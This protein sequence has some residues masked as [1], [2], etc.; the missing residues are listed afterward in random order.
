MRLVVHAGFHKTG[1][2]SVQAMLRKNAT[3]LS[4]HL[5][6]LLKADFDGLAEASRSFSL[7]PSEE[8][9]TTA[10]GRAARMLRRIDPADPRPV[11]ISSEDLSGTLPGRRGLEGYDAAPLLLAGLA[12]QARARFGDALDLTF[13]FSTREAGAWLRSTWWQ[14]LRS[15]RL[16]LSF[17]DYAAGL[18]TAADMA[19]VLEEVAAAVAPATVVSERLEISRDR[20]EGPL[21]PLLDL[22]ALPGEVRARLVTLPP[23]NA[24]PDIG[25]AEVFLALNRSGFSEESLREIKKKLRRIA[26]RDAES[27]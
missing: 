15:T 9:L 25:L 13:Y 7:R 23:V 17:E 14:N 24:E 16:Q 22:V 27:G 5:R 26:N 12:E 3:L 6:I 19:R 2:S 1:T 4:P 21:S 18:A 11:L 10:G 20:P 8:A